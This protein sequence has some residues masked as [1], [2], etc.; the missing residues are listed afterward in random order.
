MLLA[1]SGTACECGIT[2][3]P[4]VDDDDIVVPD[5]DD[6]GDDDTFNDSEDCSNGL[7][8]DGDG[9]IDC[10]DSDCELD[11]QCSHNCVPA[12]VISCGDVI[13]A[14]NGA[15]GSSDAV[16]V[17]G[18]TTWDESGPEWTFDFEPD[19]TEEVT[20][21]LTTSGMG[22]LDLFV[23]DAAFDCDG[24]ACVAYGA[25][26]LHFTAQQ[27]EAYY[28]VVDGYA[29]GQDNFTLEVL[30]PSGGG[31]GENCENGTDDDGDGAV[32]CDD[33]DC[34]TDPACLE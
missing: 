14:N 23:L 24:Q 20:L 22:N 12:D 10:A 21:V 8:D 7:D 6:T 34:A 31:D 4:V 11:P 1:L 27:G 15:A 13:T 18:C 30:C 32:D 19:T 2:E 16:D 17:Y 9:D 26:S 28:I 29:G 33:T 25:S 3:S 5:D